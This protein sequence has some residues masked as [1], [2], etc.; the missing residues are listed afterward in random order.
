MFV[1]QIRN[2]VEELREARPRPYDPV[3]EPV[4]HTWADQVAWERLRRESLAHSVWRW[5]LVAND[6]GGRRCG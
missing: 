5:I 2:A 6:E 3:P 1:D 4:L